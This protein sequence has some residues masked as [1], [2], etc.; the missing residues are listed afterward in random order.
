MPST[1]PDPAP[2]HVAVGVI[3]DDRNRILISRRAAD[4]HQGDL[5]EFPGGKVEPGE[6]VLDALQR[7]LLE[8]L[9]IQVLGSIPL[10]V[11]EHDYGDKAV[12][13]DVHVVDRFENEARA[14]EGQPLRWVSCGQL[15]ELPFPAA[16]VPIITAVK[17]FFESAI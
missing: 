5:W 7:E 13:L 2:V 8:E 14:M 16:N 3:V 10:T 9:D 6:S 17:R 1:V 4:V 11:I 12:K 15:A